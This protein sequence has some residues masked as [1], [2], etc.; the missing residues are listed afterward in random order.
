M[1]YEQLYISDGET[2]NRYMGSAMV[3]AAD[4]VVYFRLSVEHEESLHLIA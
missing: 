3:S 4:V 2:A 1:L